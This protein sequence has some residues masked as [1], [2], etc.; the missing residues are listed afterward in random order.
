MST[1]LL[2][3]ATDSAIERLATAMGLGARRRPPFGE[4]IRVGAN[5]STL[6]RYER[7]RDDD[8]PGHLNSGCNRFRFKRHAPVNASSR[9]LFEGFTERMTDFLAD[10]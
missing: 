7:R 9:G 5:H 10:Y 1:Q 8:H 6:V 2:M 3:R 4:A